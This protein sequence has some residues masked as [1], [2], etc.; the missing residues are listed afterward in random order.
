MAVISVSMINGS[1]IQ[2]VASWTCPT[3]S[4]LGGPAKVISHILVM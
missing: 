3:T 4:L 1:L 2:G